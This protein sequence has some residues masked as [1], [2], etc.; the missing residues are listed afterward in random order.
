MTLMVAQEMARGRWMAQVDLA[1]RNTKNCRTCCC[2]QRIWIEESNNECRI[3]PQLMLTEHID[4]QKSYGLKTL[5]QEM[6]HLDW[7]AWCGKAFW[8]L[9]ALGSCAVSSNQFLGLGFDGHQYHHMNSQHHVGELLCMRVVLAY[10]RMQRYIFACVPQL[11][12]FRT[13]V[14]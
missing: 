7:C 6:I 12:H 2:V 11:L 8:I 3:L 14:C 10:R 4:D 9:N 13:A 1:R 5:D